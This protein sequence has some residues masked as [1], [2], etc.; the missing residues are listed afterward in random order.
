MVGKVLEWA[1]AGCCVLGPEAK[2]CNHGKAAVYNLVLLVFLVQTLVTA[3]EANGVKQT[4]TCVETETTVV[5]IMAY[6]GCREDCGKCG[7]SHMLRQ[8]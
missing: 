1:L 5:Y 4:A 3:A 7:S 6:I 2:V 8:L